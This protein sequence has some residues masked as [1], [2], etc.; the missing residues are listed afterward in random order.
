MQSEAGEEAENPEQV[1]A[2]CAEKF[3][4]PDYIMEPGIF[5]QLKRY[6]QSGGNPLQVIEELSQNYTAVAQMANL[7]AEWLIIGGRQNNF[8]IKFENNHFSF[9]GVK[10]TDVQ[11]MVENHLKEMILKTFDPKKADTIFTE[12]GETPA[13]L[14]QLIEHP[15]WRSL[16]YRL[17]EEYPDCLMLN[18]T[19]K[20]FKSRNTVVSTF[21]FYINIFTAYF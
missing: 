2:E 6:F 19:I 9:I 20:V 12:E 13:W 1:L 18:F 5:S 14:T 3:S 11:A 21:L 7:I 10:V 4:T 15:T 17:A 16:I 8:Y